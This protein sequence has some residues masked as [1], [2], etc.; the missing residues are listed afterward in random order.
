M[1]K[2]FLLF[3]LL[4]LLNPSSTLGQTNNLDEDVEEPTPSVKNSIDQIKDKVTDKVEKL[5]LVEKRGITGTV[6]SVSGNLIKINDINENIRIIEVDELTKYSSDSNSFDLS[7]IK[8]GLQVSAI[9]I[10]NKDSEK[11]LA[12]FVNEISIPT[13]VNG[14]ITEK[15]EDDS[16]LTLTTEDE[17]KYIINVENITKVFSFSDEDLTSSEFSDLEI[18]KN[19]VVVGFPDKNNEE[20][21]SATKII[22]FPN[23]PKNPRINV[24]SPKTT[25][26]NSPTS[27]PAPEE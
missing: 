2:I 23:L 4:I 25:T 10:Y 14:V 8:P 12:R 26:S 21:I 16:V 5:N 17:K 24:D 7:D 19:A 11:L 1:K 15:N 20:K 18:L 13:F 27:S 3:T 22:F 9:G 6:E